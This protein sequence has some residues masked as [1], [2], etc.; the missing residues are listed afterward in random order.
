MNVTVKQR[1]AEKYV[2]PKK[3]LKPF[4]GSGNRLGSE[5]PG[6]TTGF[7]STTPPPKADNT[8]SHAAPVAAPSPPVVAALANMNEQ[9]TTIQIRLADGTRMVTKFN[10]TQTVGDIVRFINM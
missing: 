5:I 3:V 10:P 6:E 7:S 9:L 8:S 4:S 2:P 1:I